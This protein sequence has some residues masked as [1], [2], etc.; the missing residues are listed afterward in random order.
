MDRI[1]VNPDICNGKAVIKGTRITVAT[2]LGFLSAGDSY[3]D[4]LEAY[5]R[6]SKEDIM[7]CLQYAH[8]IVNNHSAIKTT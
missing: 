1:E 4:I 6:I 2:I 8:K 7:A 3:E 5:P